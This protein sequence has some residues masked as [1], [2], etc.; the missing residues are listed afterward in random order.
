V[1]LPLP[2]LELQLGSLHLSLRVS[3][4]VSLEVS[5][6]AVECV[7]ANARP[8]SLARALHLRFTHIRVH[9]RHGRPS[10]SGRPGSSAR[11]LRD[12]SDALAT[13]DPPATARPRERFKSDARTR[14]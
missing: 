11:V 10:P 5:R 2:N 9:A 1:A 14:A 7:V 8:A 6:L 3:L 12:M 4:R 13:L